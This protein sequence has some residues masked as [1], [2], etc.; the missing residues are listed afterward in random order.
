MART[1]GEIMEMEQLLREFFEK[2]GVVRRYPAHYRTKG[3]DPYS[4]WARRTQ[5]EVKVDA[6]GRGR[7]RIK[8]SSS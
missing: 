4:V 2:G 1:R 5:K 6:S 3:Y 7:E 8:R